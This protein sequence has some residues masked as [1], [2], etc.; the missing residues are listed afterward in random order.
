MQCGGT[1]NGKSEKVPT[2]QTDLTALFH[3]LYWAIHA[4]L[5]HLGPPVLRVA[6]LIG[7][8]SSMNVSTNMCALVVGVY[9]GWDLESRKSLISKAVKLC[10]GTLW[11]ILPKSIRLPISAKATLLYVW[12]SG[13]A[14]TRASMKQFSSVL[15]KKPGV[16]YRMET[17]S[18]RHLLNSEN[19]TSKPCVVS[20]TAHTPDTGS[21]SDAGSCTLPRPTYLHKF[22]T[23]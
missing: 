1:S 16:A 4:C 8:S 12:V 14:K 10:F 5:C 2:K 11:R 6:L 18:T 20:S 3:S 17:R 21:L 23:L 22:S 9:V 15:N 7:M 13:D 19:T